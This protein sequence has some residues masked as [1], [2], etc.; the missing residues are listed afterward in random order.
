MHVNMHVITNM[1]DNASNM[2]SI[3]PLPLLESML[4]VSWEA[5]RIKGTDRGIYVEDHRP[6]GNI[7]ISLT[8]GKY[9]ATRRL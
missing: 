2:G 5:I 9:Q 1:L 7:N 4:L 3:M 8:T 6:Q